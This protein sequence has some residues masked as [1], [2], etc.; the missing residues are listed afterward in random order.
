MCATFWVIENNEIYRCTIIK[1][2]FFNHV[3]VNIQLN[4]DNLTRCCIKDNLQSP[5]FSALG[6]VFA[7]EL[8]LVMKYTSTPQDREWILRPL[9]SATLRPIIMHK[10]SQTK[11]TNRCLL[12]GAKF[13]TRMYGCA[14]IGW[15][16][17]FHSKRSRK[18]EKNNLLIFFRTQ[19]FLCTNK[20]EVVK[21]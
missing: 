20:G 5:I 15:L 16:S 8:S 21:D 6:T 17:V 10:F 2:S 19:S 18:L 1:N 3:I 13:K 14:H 7:S 4:R 11:G 9:S 12:M